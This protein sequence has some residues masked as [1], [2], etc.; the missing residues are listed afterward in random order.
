MRAGNP[1][2]PELARLQPYPFQ[3]LAELIAGVHPPADRGLIRLSVGEPQH[4]SPQIVLD[5]IVRQLKGLSSYPSTRGMDA[6]RAAIA[7]WC[8]RRFQLTRAPLDPGRHVLP[9]SGT[10]E[11]LFSIV[12]AV[13]D[14]K[15]HARPVVIM[16]NPFYQIYEGATFLAGAEPYFLNT[17]AAD[18]YRMNWEDVPDEIWSRTQLVFTC[19]P[20][21]P[22]GAVLTRDAYQQLIE[23]AGRYD[24]VI[25]ADECYSEIYFDEAHPPL[26]LLQ[27]AQDMGV[28]DYRR[29]VIFHSLSKR[30][31]LPGLR[32]G[33]I[34]GD[35]SL[36][37]D[38]L[39]Y[40]TY[41]GCT[42]S[43]LAQAASI[44]AWGDEAH[45]RE[46]RAQYRAK[47]D[48]V[49][50]VLSGALDVQRPEAG[51][52]LWADTGT[53]D[54]TFT[55][56]L[57]RHEHV[58]VLPGSYLSRDARGLNPGRNRVRMALV[59]PLAE[60]VEAAQR[61]RRFVESRSG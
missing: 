60:C 12:A 5:E 41:Q 22:T 45:V 52:Y 11:A 56:E 16:P 40:R 37:Q 33:F 38:Y 50:G 31:N 43:S 26:G 61:I 34:A 3:K 39:Q 59:A 14:R 9:A 20:G 25:A 29:C 24:F 1:M 19:S 27:V 35:G 2:N 49:L 51:F 7:G 48:V 57:Y 58:L 21:N 55:R 8:N 36:V 32:A 47:F 18:D 17:L 44:V 42:V 54:E 4:P 13:I 23:L 28:E 6:L 10:R 15:R 30:S 46:N 53:S